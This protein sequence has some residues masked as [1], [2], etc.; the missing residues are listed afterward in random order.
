MRT[1]KI[2]TKDQGDCMTI[3]R[4]PEVYYLII[5]TKTGESWNGKKWAKW[6]K[7]YKNINRKIA[8]KLGKGVV[9]KSYYINCYGSVI[10]NT[11]YESKV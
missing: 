3:Q 6:G 2:Q 9:I 4:K 1:F 7:H 10:V 8:D 5:N 11:Q